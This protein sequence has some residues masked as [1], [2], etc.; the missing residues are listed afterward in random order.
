MA[1][2]VKVRQP[3][4]SALRRLHSALEADCNARQRRRIEAIL[5][6]GAGVEASTIADGLGSHVNT[7]YADLRAFEQDGVHCVRQPLMGGGE[8]RACAREKKS[9]C[10]K[11]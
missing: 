3:R 9:F 4:A 6:H 1:R 5:L 11:T 10:W 8:G 2:S 7:I